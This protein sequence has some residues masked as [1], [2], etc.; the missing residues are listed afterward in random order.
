MKIELYYKITNMV[1]FKYICLKLAKSE[2]YC[3][4]NFTG[5]LD[6]TC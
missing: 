3:K 5:F 1:T 4:T 6:K 2:N